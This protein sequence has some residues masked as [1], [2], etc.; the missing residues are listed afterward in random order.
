[1]RR[2]IIGGAVVSVLVAAGAAL[3]APFNTYTADIKYSR[4]IG[5]KTSPVPVGYS[6]TLG[7]AGTGGNRAAPLIHLKTITYGLRS[8]GRFFPTCSVARINAVKNDRSCPKRALVAQGPVT[9]LLGPANQPTSP[10][11]PCN[12]YLHVWNGGQGNVTF[13]F[14]IIAPKHTCGG[15]HTGSSAAWSATLRNVGK[16]LVLDDP[17]PPDISTKAGGITGVYSSLIRY[18]VVAKKLTTRVKGRTV[19]YLESVGCKA[20]KRPWTQSFTAHDFSGATETQ[21]LTG[22]SMC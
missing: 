19:G 18:T 16:N 1:V 2:T 20:G 4:G 6:Q 8:N 21:V 22:S 11:T 10:G 13:F 3:A 9:A 17:L 15:L 14:T 7:A 12:P 5:T